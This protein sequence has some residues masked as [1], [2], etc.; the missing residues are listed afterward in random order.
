[1]RDNKIVLSTIRQENCVIAGQ[2]DESP[3]L[4]LGAQRLEVF[5]S[6]FSMPFIGPFRPISSSES[7]TQTH[8]E[9]VE[10]VNQDA[11]GR[12]CSPSRQSPPHDNLG[13][14]DGSLA[15]WVRNKQRA[16]TRG[17]NQTTQISCVTSDR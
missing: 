4:D 3:Y 14:Y 5:P 17:W 2:P 13:E 8:E 1:M 10:N 15:V 6:R 16:K 7:P 12:E 11:K 9:R